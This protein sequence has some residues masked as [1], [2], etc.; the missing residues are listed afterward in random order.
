MLSGLRS[1]NLAAAANS[2]ITESKFRPACIESSD[3]PLDA[4]TQRS[5]NL[6]SE[7]RFHS[8][9]SVVASGSPASF[10]VSRISF[11]KPSTFLASGDRI[12][13]TMVESANTSSNSSSV[14]ASDS[15]C[16]LLKDLLRRA[17]PNPSSPQTSETSSCCAW[18]KLSS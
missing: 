15:G 4:T 6:V 12:K 14:V 16:A 1:V 17:R 11:K 9:A 5:S 3:T 18:G 2:V 8:S 13:E 10:L 7:T